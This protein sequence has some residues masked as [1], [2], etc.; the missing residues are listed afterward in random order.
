MQYRNST[1]SRNSFVSTEIFNINSHN[2]AKLSSQQLT[3]VQKSKL[4]Y[5]NGVINIIN[6]NLPPLAPTHLLTSL[7]A[8]LSTT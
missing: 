5:K 1:F 6:A 2:K 8:I 7:L 3:P 4:E